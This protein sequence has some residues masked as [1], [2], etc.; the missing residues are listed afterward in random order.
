MDDKLTTPSVKGKSITINLSEVKFPE[1]EV[2][3]LCL[4]C[5]RAVPI[6]HSDPGIQIC[7]EC[8]TRLKSILYPDESGNLQ[9]WEDVPPTQYPDRYRSCGIACPDCGEELVVDTMVVLT[10]Y[11]A[12]RSY[13]CKSCGWVGVK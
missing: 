11:P 10:T 7:R 12:K 1:T 3:T 4:I 8:R 9:K 6:S 13:T 5:E 2:C